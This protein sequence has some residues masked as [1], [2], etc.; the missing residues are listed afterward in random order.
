MGKL[1]VYFYTLKPGKTNSPYHYHVANEDMYYIISGYG[2]L[3]TPDGDKDVSEG[4]VIF[5]PVKEQ[6]AHKLTNTSDTPLVYLEVKTSTVPEICVQPDSK[7][8][9]LIAPPT[10]FGK[11]IRNGFGRKLS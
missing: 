8:Y 7:K 6:G 5:M 4:D 11:S 1:E 3:K 9:V 10:V 2:T